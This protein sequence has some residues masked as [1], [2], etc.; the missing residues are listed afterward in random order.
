MGIAADYQPYTI[1]HCI[2]RRIYDVDRSK[3]PQIENWIRNEPNLTKKISSVCALFSEIDK[4]HPP[5][6]SFPNYTKYNESNAVRQMTANDV[7]I[8]SFEARLLSDEDAEVL[9]GDDVISFHMFYWTLT[10]NL[11]FRLLEFSQMNPFKFIF[12]FGSDIL[13]R[14]QIVL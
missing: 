7:S 1:P 2:A 12:L 9:I 10:V 5:P 3:I 8:R 4:R 6:Q 14:V 13:I 11:R